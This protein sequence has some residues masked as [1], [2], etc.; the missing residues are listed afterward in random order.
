MHVCTRAYVCVFWCVCAHMFSSTYGGAG[1][2]GHHMLHAL[3][4]SGERFLD[5]DTQYSTEY[6]SGTESREAVNDRIEPY[7]GDLSKVSMGV[8]VCLCVCTRSYTRS[9]EYRIFCRRLEGFV[10]HGISQ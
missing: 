4:G 10:L 2:G 7:P 3:Q 5:G 1:Q 6:E 9:K 8:S